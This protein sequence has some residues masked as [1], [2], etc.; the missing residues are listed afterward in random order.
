MVLCL[1]LYV[2]SVNVP[3]L[4]EYWQNFGGIYLGIFLVY[5]NLT[6]QCN[7]SPEE[8]G[9]SVAITDRIGTYIHIY[10]H[11]YAHTFIHSYSH[12]YIYSRTPML[13]YHILKLSNYVAFFC[14]LRLLC[15]LL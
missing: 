13:T 4:T 2:P 14:T 7:L 15:I 3:V 10:T 12:T 5:A 9:G 8:E 1:D 6:I 11:T